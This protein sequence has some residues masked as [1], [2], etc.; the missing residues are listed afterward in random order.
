MREEKTSSITKNFIYSIGYQVL[1]L[2]VPLISTPYVSRILSAD[3][4]GVYSYTSSIMAFFMLFAALGTQSYA[5]REVSRNR[6][7]KEHISRL[8]WEIE[9]MTFMTTFACLIVWIFLAFMNK[10][11][12]WYFLALVPM[13]IGI[14]FDIS[15]LFNGYEKVKYIVFRNSF[16]KIVSVALLFLFVKEKNDLL[17]YFWITSFSTLLGNLS[18]WTYLPG[19]L[20][21]VSFKGLS[22]KEHFKETI[23]YFIPTVATSVYTLLDKTL[24]GLITKD[25]FENGFYEQ[26]TKII[27][28]IK[29]FVFAALNSVVGVRTSYL[30]VQ[31]KHDEIKEHIHRSLNIILLLGYGVLFGLV[32]VVQN[33]VPVFFG[34]GYE[35]VVGLLI[36]MAPMPVI[37]GISNCL[38]SQYYT[39]VGKRQLSAKFIVTGAGIN[40]ILNVLLI[41]FWGAIGA[42][43]A[44]VFAEILITVLY[45]RYCQRY[46]TLSDIWECSYKRIVCGIVMLLSVYFL[47]QVL[48]LELILE[49][50]IQV[51][52]GTVIYGI[53]LLALKDRVLFDFLNHVLKVVRN[54]TRKK[55]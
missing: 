43:I 36:L 24:I 13:L 21:K 17:L 39:P 3:G 20:R 50:L 44:S 10:E 53:G 40:L 46:I 26:A 42:T 19:M 9:I 12:K 23:V 25:S 52:A 6:K 34:A 27:G 4:V 32:G 16:C 48:E 55:E 5:T 54:K 35:P 49:L 41:P 31:N 51:V 33:F 18:M 29:V 37:I 8:F 45:V 28:V 38:G 30:F 2:I 11:N 1:I 14:P 47:G 22:I 15:W 7:N